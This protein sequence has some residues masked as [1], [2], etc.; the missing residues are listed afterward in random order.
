M[1]VDLCVLILPQM[2]YINS[3]LLIPAASGSALFMNKDIKRLAYLIKQLKVV[4]E[5]TIAR[6]EAGLKPITDSL[7]KPSTNSKLPTRD[8]SST[9]KSVV[10]VEPSL[11]KPIV[12]MG[13]RKGSI[14]WIAWPVDHIPPVPEAFVIQPLH[15]FAGL[16]L[17]MRDLVHEQIRQD[18]VNFA[19]APYLL[20]DSELLPGP[21]RIELDRDPPIALN[22]DVTVYGIR[23]QNW[24]IKYQSNCRSLNQSMMDLERDFMFLGKV[25]FLKVS[26]APVFLSPPVK[27]P[28]F[29]TPKTRFTMIDHEY[30]TCAADVRSYVR[31][32]VM[33]RAG[34]TVWH[35]MTDMA[36]TAIRDRFRLA[37]KMAMNVIENLEK[38]H[39]IGVVHGD[40]HPGNLVRLQDDRFGLIDFGRAFFEA[41]M[42]HAKA[43]FSTHCYLSHW[44]LQGHRFGF[45]DDVYKTLLAASFIAVPGR[46]DDCVALGATEAKRSD[47]ITMHANDGLFH[48]KNEESFKIAF[49]DITKRASIRLSLWNALKVAR[50]VPSVEIRP[51]YSGIIT[52]LTTALTNMS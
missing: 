52:H 50:S 1:T 15:D 33:E 12:E 48:P 21:V 8:N 30:E 29:R 35:Y 28:A 20:Y 24:V 13:L 25:E 44:N 22:V 41:D 18:G 5:H 16:S 14:D 17:R 26:P 47:L 42:S 10:H 6:A 39:S 31:Y 43:S 9:E 11:E 45:R 34:A 7:P 23:G 32:M 38:I 51:D 3:L 46:Y 37:I 2:R 49:P 19:S 36:L 27:L 4:E 40:I